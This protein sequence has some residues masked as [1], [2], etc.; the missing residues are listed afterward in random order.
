[1]KKSIGREVRLFSREMDTIDV[2]AGLKGN[3]KNISA[4]IDA[5]PPFR[6]FRIRKRLR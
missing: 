4:A 3:A 1:M 5:T 2:T 6:C